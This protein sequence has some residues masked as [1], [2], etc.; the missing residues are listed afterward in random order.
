[1]AGRDGGEASALQTLLRL[2]RASEDQAELALAQ[3]VTA[4]T[5]A[6]AVRLGAA[7]AEKDARSLLAAAREERVRTVPRAA[8]E[9]VSLRAREER[10]AEI[11]ALRAA[12]LRGAEEQVARA[13]AGV[14]A[15]REALAAVSREREAHQR[16]LDRREV[17]AARQ[18]ERRAEAARDD[19][20]ATGKPEG[21]D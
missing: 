15:A 2:E 11:W 16:Q 19:Q 17:A 5:A 21:E 7:S 8:R 20:P 13:A 18:R 10:L 4:A 14:T 12:E 9:L 1:M 6:E 3:A